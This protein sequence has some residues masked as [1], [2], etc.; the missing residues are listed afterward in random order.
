MDNF[1]P[2]RN[3][4][5]EHIQEG[6]L[7]PFD[8]G[9]YTALHLLSDWSTGVC[10]AC[11]LSIAFFFGN[12]SWKTRIQK[13][14]RRLRDRGYIHYPKGRGGRGAYPI[15]IHKY[16]VTVGKLK[17][18]RLNAWKHGNLG[19]PEYESWTGE[20][21]VEARSRNGAST[22]EEPNLD[23]KTS[24]DVQD[25]KEKAISSNSVEFDQLKLVFE[26]Y[27]EK[28]S[29]NPKTYAFT[30]N[31][32]KKARARLR[33][34]LTKTGGD[35]PKAICLMKL[36]IDGLVASAFHMGEDPKTR[37]T[38]YIEW[39]KHLFNSYEQMEHWWNAMSTAPSKP[40]GHGV[41]VSA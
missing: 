41:G 10:H 11:A 9:V 34:C 18:T 25:E 32:K 33:E 22:V 26:Y 15:L 14:L 24:L 20:R 36:A 6:K 2:I 1:T 39:E 4:L 40:N 12:P 21:T 16:E 19:K 38:R 17:G 35:I 27:L 13:S 8:L 23:L 5:R 28:T 3:G 37:G 30:D 29:R 7:P 31:R